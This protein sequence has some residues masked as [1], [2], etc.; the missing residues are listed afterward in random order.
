[1]TQAAE[2][3]NHLVD[4]LDGAAH[5][6]DRILSEL[7]IIE[8]HRKILQRQAQ[9]VRGVFQVV[10]KKGRKCLEGLELLGL[11][12]LVG[13]RAV[14]QRRRKLTSDATKE[15]HFLVAVR[16][17]VH[18]VHQHHQ[19]HQAVGGG[20]RDDQ[21]VAAVAELARTVLPEDFRPRPLSI[22][23]VKGTANAVDFA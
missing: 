2:L 19:P 18:T 5:R 4:P 17:A 10:D 1:M 12:D 14:E 9:A 21:S 23:Q 6:P 11:K 16:H 22:L 13:E 8:V 7:R 15:I 20:Q 3:Q